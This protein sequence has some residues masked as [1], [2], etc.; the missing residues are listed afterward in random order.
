M[1]PSHRLSALHRSATKRLKKLR[2]NASALHFPVNPNEDLTVAWTT[3]ESANLWSGFLRAYYLSGAIRTKTISGAIVKFQS[4]KFADIASAMRFAIQ[5]LKNRSFSKPTISR[6]DEPTWH[7]HAAFL[8]LQKAVSPTNL[9]QVYAAFSIRMTFPSFL[10]TVRNF[11]AHRCDETFRKATGVAVKLGMAT[12]PKLRPTTIVCSRLP[13]RPQNLL[14]D[15]LD[16]MKDV[17]DLLCS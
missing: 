3:I 9:R 7:D 4:A 6:R 13:K 15:W 12:K 1:N 11:Y 8:K 14:T 2:A 17:I 10:P 5:N 16:E